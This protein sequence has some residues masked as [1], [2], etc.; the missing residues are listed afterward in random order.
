[1]SLFDQ[2]FEYLIQNVFNPTNEEFE[3]FDYDS[4]EYSHL[5]RRKEYFELLL[6]ELGEVGWELIET[7]NNNYKKEDKGEIA[8]LLFK[9]SSWSKHYGSGLGV[10]LLFIDKLA[11]EKAE[12]NHISFDNADTKE[13]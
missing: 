8:K 10:D 9:R 5:E 1:M 4:K 2:K 12:A 13:S 11:K 6:N 3:K 7:T